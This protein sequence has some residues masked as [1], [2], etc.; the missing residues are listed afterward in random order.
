MRELSVYYCRKCGYYAYYYLPKNAV[1]PRCR[2]SMTLLNIRYQDFMNLDLEERDRLIACRIIESSPTLVHRICRPEE[3]YN[4]RQLIGKLVEE[5]SRLSE[6]NRE[7]NH[8]VDWMHKT[9]WEQLH[10]TQELERALEQQK[11]A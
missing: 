5:V 2:I 3:L 4:Q 11:N 8:T 1:C 10:R 6:E 9:I 7:L